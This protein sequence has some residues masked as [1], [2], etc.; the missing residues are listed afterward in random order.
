M[1]ENLAIDEIKKSY[2]AGVLLNVDLN[3]P[4]LKYLQI[5]PSTLERQPIHIRDIITNINEVKWVIP[6]FQRYYDWEPD[7]VRD[8]LT[9]IMM[10][11]YVG[12]LLLWDSKE[13]EKLD[14]KPIRGVDESKKESPNALV[15]LDGQQ[16]ITSLNYA[17]N[18]Q[19]PEKNK[20]D[21]KFP[22]YYYIDLKAFLENSS[23]LI[24]RHDTKL[25]DKATLEEFLF[26]FYYLKDS[27]ITDWIETFQNQFLD[28]NVDIQLKTAKACGKIQ[29]KLFTMIGQFEIPLVVLPKSI[30][31]DAVAAIFENLNSKGKALGTF[32]LLIVRLSRYK[33]ELKNMWDN[34]LEEHAKI[35]EY[36]EESPKMTKLGLYIMESISLA[37][38]RKRSCKRKDILDLFVANKETTRTFLQKWNTMS[39]YVEHAIKYLEDTLGALGKK[40]LPYEPIIPIL[41]ALLHVIHEKFRDREPGCIDKL[42]Y[43][44]WTSVFGTRFSSAVD[45]KK[46][47]DFGEMIQWFEDNSKIPAD[48]RNFRES[49]KSMVHLRDI[50]KRKSSIYL[51][52]FSLLTKNG[53]SDLQK[54]I[55]MD[56][57]NLHMDHIFPKSKYKDQDG[58]QDSIINMTWLTRE[59]N[60]KS[61]RDMLPSEYIGVLLKAWEGN[62]EGLSKTLRAH[63]MNDKCIEYLKKN[64]FKKFIDERE[65]I[66]LDSIGKAIG[67]RS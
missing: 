11:Y 43:W 56:E 9:S 28:Q 23:D 40:D 5:P 67:A 16:R 20:L 32:D 31:F 21:K 55:I 30:E 18:P 1:K 17:I 29:Q 26:P 44:Y 57:K 27:Y 38:T 60:I 39:L 33:V 24:V 22:G 4:H 51:G 14:C 45:S 10:G 12:S 3:L 8:L 49:Y 48:I 52:M 47:S 25:S 64:D 37:Y 41:A 50:R 19:S 2:L 34:T 42:H 35:K 46:T 7:D 6:N 63:F 65:K 53:A 13:D 66:M 15:V 58:L 36:F 59:T 61:K 62:M 54:K